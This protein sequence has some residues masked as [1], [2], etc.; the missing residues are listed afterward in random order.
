MSAD[1]MY[2]IERDDASA[3]WFDAAADG[4]LLIRQ[5]DQGHLGP[6]QATTCPLCGSTDMQWVEASGRGVIASYAVVHRRD[7][8]PLPLAIVELDEG[9]WLRAQVQNANANQ[10]R[11]GAAVEIRFARPDGGEPIPYAVPA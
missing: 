8:E 10:L 3:E 5:C 9:P 6:P 2:A 7:A 4:R 11:V 1:N